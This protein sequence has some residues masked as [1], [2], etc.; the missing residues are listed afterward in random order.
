VYWH[1]WLA[2]LNRCTDPRKRKIATAKITVKA[3]RYLYWV[4]RNEFAPGILLHVIRIV[5]KSW[6]EFI[7]ILKSNK[8]PRTNMKLK[9]YLL[10]LVCTFLIDAAF[11]SDKCS[12]YGK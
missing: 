8:R 5:D 1:G 10:V 9:I 3:A 7:Y 11:K 6:H 2:V 12:A 4:K